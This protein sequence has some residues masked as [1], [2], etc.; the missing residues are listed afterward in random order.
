MQRIV[1]E[2][3]AVGSVAAHMDFCVCF[4]DLPRLC[5]ATAAVLAAAAPPLAALPVRQPHQ[6]ARAPQAQN[7]AQAALAAAQTLQATV[8]TPTRTVPAWL[9]F[10]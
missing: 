5:F 1:A 2:P 3:I 9:A 4:L 10:S 8:Y 6:I 7:L